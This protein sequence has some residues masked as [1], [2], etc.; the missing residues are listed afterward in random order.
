MRLIIN[1]EE[2]MIAEIAVERDDVYVGSREDCMVHLPDARI[3]PHQAVIAP[4]KGE[5]QFR[6]LENEPTVE[7]NGRP[8]QED[9]TLKTGDEIRIFDF[10]IRVFPA[11][12]GAAAATDGRSKKVAR[13][14]QFAQTHLPAGAQTK[15]SDESLHLHEGQLQ[16]L[17]KVAVRMSQTASVEGVMDAALKVL[18]ELFAAHRVWVGVRRVNYGAM[19]YVEGRRSTGQM[20][21]LPEVGESL[22]VRA[23]DR[24]QFVIVPRL[25]AQDHTAVLVGPLAG[26]ENT[27]GMLYLDSGPEGRRY[28]LHDLE[29]FMAVSGQ[30]AAQLDAIFQQLA[31]NRSEMMSGE[32]QVAHAIQSRLTPRKLPQWEEISFGAF[33]EQGS[34]HSGDFYDIVKLPSGQAMFVVA[35]T[36]GEGAVPSMLTAQIQAAFR[37]GAMHQ[38]APHVL[39]KSLNWIMYDG[40]KDH[41]LHA[42]VGV[43]DPGSGTVQYATAGSLGAYVIGQRGDERG[44]LPAPPQTAL[45]MNRTTD[46][47]LLSEQLESGETL[48]LFT[49]GV[50]TASNRAG[51]VFGEERFVDIL[52][53]GFGQVVSSMLKEMLNDLRAF[54]EGGKLPSDI[55]VLLAHRA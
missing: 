15:K 50:V 1:Q 2:S 48:A 43:L 29:F 19:E 23:L 35:H 47:T 17:G 54:T 9:F 41:P 13:L 25:S 52:C 20:T 11:E 39:L 16:T 18:F 55:T 40:Q 21:E 27:L 51:E 36:P 33:R 42:F 24:N 12:H 4:Q 3:A 34:E 53:D 32:V 31:R 8:V 10:L 22:K 7:V 45:G 5:W 44:L 46:Y 28:H 26:P 49:P 37:L 38:D 14:T 6:L 30:I